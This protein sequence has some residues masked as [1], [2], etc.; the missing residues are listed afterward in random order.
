MKF[1][2]F[3]FTKTDDL[4]WHVE[5]EQ[6]ITRSKKPEKN[7]TAKLVHVGWYPTLGAACLDVAHLITDTE[8]EAAKD[9]EEYATRLKRIGAEIV[10]AVEKGEK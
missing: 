10:R 2:D 3:L 7:G 8:T 9:L 6:I 4:N 5:Q 1:R